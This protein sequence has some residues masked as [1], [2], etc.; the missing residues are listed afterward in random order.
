MKMIEDKDGQTEYSAWDNKSERI[1]TFRET[2]GYQ[3]ITFRS[4]DDKFSDVYHLRG[5]GY[6]IF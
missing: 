6:R 3:R 2:E 4:R 1:V 5:S